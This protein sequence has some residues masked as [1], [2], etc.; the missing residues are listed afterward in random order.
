MKDWIRDATSSDPDEAA[1]INP[2]L[3]PSVREGIVYDTA[4]T[5]E[6]SQAL[7]RRLRQDSRVE[8]RRRRPLLPVLVGSGVLLVGTAAAAT[9]GVVW[10]PDLI[11]T[12]A[13]TPSV[14][15]LQ[16]GDAHQL[17]PAIEVTG[18]GDLSVDRVTDR[19]AEVTLDNGLARFDVGAVGEQQLVVHADDVDVTVQDA[20]VTVRRLGEDVGVDA[21]QG[22][23]SVTWGEAEV[24]LQAGQGWRKGEGV[25]DALPTDADPSVDEG[26]ADE[27]I[28]PRVD[29]DQVDAVAPSAAR[30]RSVEPVVGSTPA[31]D[32][33]AAEADPCAVDSF[34]LECA[35][36]RAK[37]A[38]ARSPELRFAALERAIARVGRDPVAD[39]DLVE[40]CDTFLSQH[41]DTEWADDVRAFRVEAAFHGARSSR[42]VQVADTYLAAAAAGHAK[43]ADVQRWRDIANLRMTTLDM[44]QR[45]DCGDALPMLRDLAGLE[46]G[47]RQQ[48]ALAW[49][50]VCA[51]KT[52]AM[53]E[54]RDV[55]RQVREEDLQP[56]LRQRV[57][58]A[59]ALIPRAER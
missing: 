1:R 53:D 32:Q 3:P 6:E 42:V 49:R 44:A 12:D 30:S 47:V 9:V 23:A 58:D 8:L 19:G 5:D 11:A 27:V 45:G 31:L 7:Y 14:L 18:L 57:R 59:N 46:S 26:S 2:M 34:S 13:A 40:D 54:A 52:G 38:E 22:E 15:L 39:R 41:G 50:G 51:A 48:E 17:S 16:Q 43:R 10:V 56:S 24:R 21:D 29:P 55:L 4:S 25:A 37:K 35:R 33:P 28:V 20:I 36:S